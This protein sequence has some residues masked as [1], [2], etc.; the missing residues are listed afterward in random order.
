VFSK[1]FLK[2]SDV[3]YYDVSITIPDFVEY[4]PKNNKGKYYV[5]EWIVGKNDTRERFIKILQGVN[6]GD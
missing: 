4:L 5:T 2:Y 1:G 3:N 6:N